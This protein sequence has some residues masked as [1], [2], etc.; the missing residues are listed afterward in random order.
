[1]FS[2]ACGAETHKINKV[3]SSSNQKGISSSD[4]ALSDYSQK[5]TRGGKNVPSLSLQLGMTLT[6]RSP[7]RDKELKRASPSVT[8]LFTSLP[9]LLLVVLLLRL[10]LLL[11]DSHVAPATL[12]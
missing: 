8:A 4:A 2:Q 5:L 7:N 3:A 6:S 9:P 1:L 11:L 10:S 12:A